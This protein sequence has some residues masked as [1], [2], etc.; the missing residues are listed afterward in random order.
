M[1]WSYLGYIQ[2]TAERREVL[3]TSF[4][5]CHQSKQAICPSLVWVKKGQAQQEVEANTNYISHS[6]QF[7]FISLQ[8]PKKCH[9]P[10]H[11][12][13][14]LLSPWCVLFS[15]ICR[16]FPDFCSSS[17]SV[18][19]YIGYPQKMQLRK[20]FPISSVVHPLKYSNL[21]WSAT[22]LST[23]HFGFSFIWESHLILESKTCAFYVACG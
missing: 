12:T 18:C 21:Y 3:P 2:P 4:V 7:N 23:L 6:L 1:S 15:K 10:L 22:E 19:L 13:D 5:P 14:A 9:F 17:S 11:Y 20:I 16:C 8:T